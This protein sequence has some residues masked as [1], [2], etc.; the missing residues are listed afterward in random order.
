[1]FTTPTKF[2]QQFARAIVRIWP[3]ES[4]EW[5]QAF[6]AELPAVESASAA[7]SW[8]IGGLTLLFR[9]W[10]KHA[11]RALGRPIGS[12]SDTA[13]SSAAFTPRYSRTPRTPLW[14]MLALTVAS[15]AILL[16]PNVRQALDKLRWAYSARTCRKP[17]DWSSVKKLQANLKSNRDPQLLALLALLSSNHEERLALS[18][19]AIRKNPSLTWLDYEVSRRTWLDLDPR[20]SFPMDRVERLKKWDPQNS[21]PDILSA[22]LLARPAELEQFDAIVQGKHIPDATKRLVT[23]P[24]WISA[25]HAAFTAPKYDNYGTKSLELARN[26][27]ARFSVDDPEIVEHVLRTNREPRFDMM[28]AYVQYLTEQGDTLETSGNKQQALASYYELLRFAQRV[29]LVAQTPSE[30]Y[31]ARDI[32]EAVGKELVP[33]DDALGRSDE[34]SII[35]S[36]LEQ[37]KSE[38]DLRFFRDVPLRYRGSEFNALAWS[39]LLINVA[40][41]SLLVILP[42]ALISVLYI[43]SRRREPL[44]KRGFT[45]FLASLFA[46]ATPWLLLASSVLIYFTYHPYARM[47]AEYLQGGPGAPDMQTFFS[48]MLV[49]YAL[50]ETFQFLHDP[51]SQWSAIIAALCLLLVFFLGR[52]T[53]RRTKTTA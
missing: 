39:G 9:E 37:W 22:E 45:D 15:V 7:T 27:S 43:F 46:D 23:N 19:E 24:D 28:E 36:Q 25:M 53:L 1:M 29:A 21:A 41:L 2:N 20:D 17:A 13:D 42:L 16:H 30:Q 52:V 10:L 18:D 6:A 38:Q 49:P 4:R 44:N 3:A 5:G 48:A 40:G 32:G 47:C 50:P 8:L 26:V 51:V 12:S 35:S 33:L 14:L 34:A 11:W 31:L